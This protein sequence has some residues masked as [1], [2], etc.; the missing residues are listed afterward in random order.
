M[1]LGPLLRGLG[2]CGRQTVTGSSKFLICVPTAPFSWLENIIV[3]NSVQNFSLSSEAFK[4]SSAVFPVSKQGSHSSMSYGS[5]SQIVE[6]KFRFLSSATQGLTG[7][8]FVVSAP[9]LSDQVS[10][11]D[12][13]I[14]E[15][16]EICCEVGDEVDEGSSVVIVETH[17]ASLHIKALGHKR[18]RITKILVELNEEVKELQALFHVEPCE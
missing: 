8:E 4:T 11:V 18:L 2:A 13:L 1:S 9:N 14:G 15:V 3:D 10:L 16:E 7:N 5:S 17:K 12:G 6:A